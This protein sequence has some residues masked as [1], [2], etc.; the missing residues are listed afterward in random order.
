[1]KRKQRKTPEVASTSLLEYLIPIIPL[2]ALVPNFYIIPDL[3]Y[4]G[5]ANQELTIAVA[6]AII[7]GIGIFQIFRQPG[8]IAIDRTLV[9]LAASIGA[10]V[11]WQ[12]ISLLWSPEWSEGVRLISIWF[13]F[14]VIA[15]A[16]ALALTSKSAEWMYYTLTLVILILAAS[17]FIEYRMFEGVM[18]VCSSITASAESRDSA[19][20]ASFF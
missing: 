1:M 8:Q 4:Q 10:L 13:G 16:G 20:P 12:A 14:G 2:L 18:S 3:N 6:S 19:S 11:A 15:T 17:Q 7:L 5:L 9:W